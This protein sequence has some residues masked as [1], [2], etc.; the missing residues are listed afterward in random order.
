M[1]PNQRVNNVQLDFSSRM[2]GARKKALTPQNIMCTFLGQFKVPTDF[3]NP[4]DSDSFFV[5]FFQVKQTE[6]P[7]QDG[8]SRM[9]TLNPSA[10]FYVRNRNGGGG[11]GG[12]VDGGGRPAYL[13]MRSASMRETSYSRS[14]REELKLDKLEQG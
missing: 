3:C 1:N 10:S 4:W 8:S 12:G 11:G 13:P 9:N 5:L 6:R 14:I 7:P 2:K